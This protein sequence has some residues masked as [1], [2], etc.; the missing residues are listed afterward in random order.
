MNAFVHPSFQESALRLALGVE[1]IDALRGRRVAHPIQV[2]FDRVPF[3]F[4]RL[5]G[6][7]NPLWFQRVDALKPVP[8]H[9]SGLYALVEPLGTK[10]PQSLSVRLVDRARQ[11]VPR[12][13]QIQPDESGSAILHPALFPGAAYDV[14]KTATGMRG[15]V[16]LDPRTEAPLRWARVEAR[17]PGS[18]TI[19]GRAQGD[20]RGEFLLVLSSEASGIG[21]LDGDIEI[22]ITVFGLKPTALAPELAALPSRDPLWDLPVEVVPAP[23]MVDLVSSGEALPDGYAELLTSADPSLSSPQS[24]RL[25]SFTPGWLRTDERPFFVI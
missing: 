17:L 2:A 7:P 21:E 24:P 8:R 4:S 1:P 5:G 3:P 9:N 20:D 23:P 13:L 15:R 12:R 10:P 16:L 18:N 22:T 19:V 11:L 14:S 6:E 25:V